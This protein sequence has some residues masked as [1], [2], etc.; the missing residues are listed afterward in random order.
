V[1]NAQSRDI[2]LNVAIFAYLPDASTAVEKLEEA[3]EQRYSS[4]DLDLELWNPYDDSFKDDGLSQ[5]V[6]FDLVEIDTCR[7]DEL[8]GGAFGGLDRIPNE[9]KRGPDSYVGPAITSM[10]T[11]IG[12]YVVP[13]WVCGN[14]VQIWSSNSAVVNA[15]TYEE[16]LAVVDPTAKRPLLAAMWG[17]TGLGE[18]YTDAYLD[19]HGPEKTREHLKSMNAGTSDLDEN[20]KNAILKLI[21]ELN[22]DNQDHLSHFYNHAYLFP[23]QFATQKNSVLLGYS[24]RLYYAERELQLVPDVYP[25]SIKPEDITIRQFSFSNKSQGTPSWI[26]G[27]VIPKGRLAKKHAAIVA[28]LQFIQTND[29][30]LHFAEPAQ[31]LAPSYLLP[32]T[33]DAYAEDSA[34]VEKQPLLPK[35]HEAMSGEFPVSNSKIWQGMRKAGDK[36][37]EIIKD[38]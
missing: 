38:E 20:A 4:I 5:I 28:F 21:K 37:K 23:R 17:S 19:V 6:D 31:Y 36:L 25:P 18:Y 13:H 33:A 8:M 10:K 26:D 32:A 1:A 34:I 9:I 14:F 3:F 29:A 7:I 35:F 24:E 16:F 12:Q 27:F 15:K 30:Y 11:D 22:Q 2:D